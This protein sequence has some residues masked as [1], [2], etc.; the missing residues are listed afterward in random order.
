M[1][2]FEYVL[3]GMGSEELFVGKDNFCC[4]VGCVIVFNIVFFVGEF[5]DV[6]NVFDGIVDKWCKF[7]DGNFVF[8]NGEEVLIVF[9]GIFVCGFEIINEKCLMIFIL[10]EGGVNFKK[11][12]Y[13]CLG[14]MLKLVEDNLKGL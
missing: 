5:F 2:G 9:F 11:V 8:C 14:L 4:Y 10:G 13:W 1:I 7:G 6:W 12:F 3:S